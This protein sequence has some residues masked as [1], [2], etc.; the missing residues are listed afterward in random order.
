[1]A[2]ISIS[3]R[4][5]ELD[6]I[7]RRLGPSLLPALHRE[8]A[9]EVGE[10]VRVHL[11]RYALGHHKTATALG[12]RPT[13]NLEDARVEATSDATG[14]TV[15][16]RALGIRRALGPLVI[17]PKRRQSLT[18]PV[19]S[20]AYGRTLAYLRLRGLDIFRPKGKNYLAHTVEENGKARIEPLFILVKQ[21]T[22]KHEPAL[23]PTQGELAAN[24]LEAA[25]AFVMEGKS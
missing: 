19:A 4:T 23:L 22:L 15:T 2:E 13:G 12:A 7:E 20:I 11:R 1:M 16:V 18:I 10:T 21:V 17:R 25:R 24:A 8:I 3:V 5:P 14:A 6:G 9:A